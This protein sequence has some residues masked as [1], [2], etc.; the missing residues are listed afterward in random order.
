MKPGLSPELLRWA[1]RALGAAV[2]ALAALQQ[3]TWQGAFTAVV[4]AVGGT[5]AGTSILGPGHIDLQTLPKEIRDSVRPPKAD[6]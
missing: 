4:A 1:L 3:W 2:T 5:L 6:P